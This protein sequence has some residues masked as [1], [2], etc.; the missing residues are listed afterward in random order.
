M[1]LGGGQGDPYQRGLLGWRG[2]GCSS[3]FNIGKRVM[4]RAG[5]VAT[6]VCLVFFSLSCSLSIGS[7][8]KLMG[9]L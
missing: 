2:Y 8:R 6:K 5:S 3:G 9:Y 1:V 4:I 7:T